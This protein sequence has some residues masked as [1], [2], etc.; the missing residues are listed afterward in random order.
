MFTQHLAFVQTLLASVEDAMHVSNENIFVDEPLD[1]QMSVSVLDIVKL[2]LMFQYNAGWPIVDLKFKSTMTINEMA[3]HACNIENN[4]FM[5]TN[6]S[7]V[8][9]SAYAT[10]L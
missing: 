2:K 7:S 6:E 5:T 3:S 8:K 1:E 9:K 4:H 10:R